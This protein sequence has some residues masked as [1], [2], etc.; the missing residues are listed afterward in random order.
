MS[1]SPIDKL[2]LASVRCTR[3][4]ARYGECDCWTDKKPPVTEWL[5]P[6]GRPARIHFP[7]E[8]SRPLRGG[9]KALTVAL[10]GVGVE[11][12]RFSEDAPRVTCPECKRKLAGGGP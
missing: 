10:C 8:L 3:C 4:G 7:A 1:D 5:T 9:P 11:R 12:R 2:I 6:A